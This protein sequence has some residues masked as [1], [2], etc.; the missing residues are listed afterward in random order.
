MALDPD[1]Q[2]AFMENR[3]EL[4]EHL[5]F[6]SEAF[7]DLSPERQLPGLGGAGPIPWTAIDRYAERYGLDLEAFERL[8]RMIRIQDRLY[9]Q[10]VTEKAKAAASRG[11]AS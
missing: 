2:P 8:R 10:D 3:P 11:G 6:Y 1:W 9:L 5:A 7:H 4:F